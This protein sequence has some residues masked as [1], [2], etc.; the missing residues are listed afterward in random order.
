MH[1]RTQGRKTAPV[2]GCRAENGEGKTMMGGGVAAIGFP[3]KAPV[4]GGQPGHQAVAGHLGDDRGGGNRERDG[5]AANDK[6]FGAAEARRTIAVD[7]CEVWHAPLVPC[8]RGDGAAHREQRGLQDVDPV[9]L[10]DRTDPD[11]DDGRAADRGEQSFPV[12]FLEG[13]GIIDAVRDSGGV[14][15][16][17][18]GDHGARQ[19]PAA[20]LVDPN[21]TRYLGLA[22]EIECRSGRAS[23]GRG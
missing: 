6:L 15:H 11:A 21:D 23:A 17:G 4:I 22:F 19:R 14:E 5:V 9:D 3:A 18:R 20:G 10:G 13:L 8:Q 1:H 16:H 2:V 7:E 12:R